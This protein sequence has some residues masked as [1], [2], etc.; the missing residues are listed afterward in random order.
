MAALARPVINAGAA[1]TVLAARPPC[2]TDLREIPFVIFLFLPE[3]CD[4]AY[5]G[6][7]TLCFALKLSAARCRAKSASNAVSPSG[8]LAPPNR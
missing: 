5:A 4:P 1:K 7:A 3:T 8:S 2:N 6:T